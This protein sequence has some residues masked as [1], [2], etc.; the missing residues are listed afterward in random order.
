MQSRLITRYHPQPS[1]PSPPIPSLPSSL[2]L[3]FHPF[4]ATSI[5]ESLVPFRP[6]GGIGGTS[7]TVPAGKAL[8]SVAMKTLPLEHDSCLVF[9]A[10]LL[11][12]S[13]MIIVRVTLIANN[14]EK[15]ALGKKKEILT[16]P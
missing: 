12:T 2:V 6:P 4:L 11:I 7:I 9:T 13:K 3:T 8:P 14:L 5:T 16:I 1:A 10:T 15:Y